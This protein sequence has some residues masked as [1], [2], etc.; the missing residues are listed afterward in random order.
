VKLK[1]LSLLIINSIFFLNASAVDS[2]RLD[3]IE[4]R[5]DDIELS[6]ALDKVTLGGSF[7]NQYE[8]FHIANKRTDLLNSAPAALKTKLQY[9]S[10]DDYLSVYMM[11]AELNFDVKVTSTLNFYSTLGMSKFWNFSDR[12]GRNSTENGN[13][14]SL[15]GGYAL[16]DSAARFDVAY[17]NY[18]GTDSPWSLAMGRMTTNNGPPQNQLDGVGRSGTYPFLAYNVIFDG[19][20][21]VYRFKSLPP[22]HSLKTRLFYTPFINVDK[23]NKGEQIVDTSPD[24]ANPT[25]GDSGDKVES[26]GSFITLL[27]EYSIKG[28]SWTKKLDMFYSVYTFDG[29]YDGRRQKM[30]EGSVCNT[31]TGSTTNEDYCNSGIEYSGTTSNTLYFGI[32]KFFGSNFDLS[33]TYNTFIVRNSGDDDAFS[34]NYLATSRYTFD[35]STNSGD[36]I[37]A[38]YIKTDENKVPVD[39]N[40]I[41]VNDFYNMTNGEGFHF[42]YAKPIGTNQVVRL[43]YMQYSQ[44]ESHLLK[45]DLN[46]KVTSTYLRWKIFF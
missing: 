35:N 30:E 19:A 9:D 15:A 33:L 20:A 12:T 18:Q 34:Q 41:S 44:G 2:S 24:P 42:Y 7:F 23:N 11:R 4:S 39:S 29:Y 31:V 37:G 32:N 21:V 27:T 22:G 40:S 25:T 36:M 17:L 38:E 43:G 8:N 10:S 28:L 1:L 14:K 26:N 13:F 46:S 45:R 16:Q 6:Q 5:L 3:S